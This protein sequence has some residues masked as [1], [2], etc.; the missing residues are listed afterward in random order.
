[1]KTFDLQP[2]NNR[3]SFYNKCHVVENDGIATLFSYNTKVAQYNL[4]SKKME[5]FGWFS[6]TTA[7]HINAFLNFYGFDTCSKKQLENYN[8]A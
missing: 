8:K 1:M 2:I 4:N 5:V 6:S 3:N 7:R